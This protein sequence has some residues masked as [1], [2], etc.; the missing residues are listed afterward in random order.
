ML[1]ALFYRHAYDLV[2]LSHVSVNENGDENGERLNAFTRYPLSSPF[3]FTGSPAG[4][5]R[6]V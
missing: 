5:C 1:P 4:P 2:I 3:S 6:K